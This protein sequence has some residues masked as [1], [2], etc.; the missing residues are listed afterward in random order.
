MVDGPTLIGYSHRRL[1]LL[2]AGHVTTEYIRESGREITH[3][4]MF[5]QLLLNKGWD[6][7]FNKANVYHTL[8]TSNNC[9]GEVEV[10]KTVAIKNS[11]KYMKNKALESSELKDCSFDD[12]R[13]K[14]TNSKTVR[15]NADQRLFWRHNG[16]HLVKRCFTFGVVIP[17]TTMKIQNGFAELDIYVATPNYLQHSLPANSAE[18]VHFKVAPGTETLINFAFIL[19]AKRICLF[20]LI[21]TNTVE[22]SGVMIMDSF[23]VAHDNITVPSDSSDEIVVPDKLEYLMKY[24]ALPENEEIPEMPNNMVDYILNYSDKFSAPTI[25]CLTDNTIEGTTISV[26]DFSKIPKECVDLYDKIYSD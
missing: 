2:A 11:E 9:V 23:E 18:F 12:V 1:L 6:Q 8:L 19:V 26:N 16:I 20:E 4:I 15:K 5:S 7:F 24:I 25:E 10:E 17:K 13:K 22:N 14:L 21:E 3:F